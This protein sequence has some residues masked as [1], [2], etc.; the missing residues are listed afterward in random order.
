MRREGNGQRN[1]LTPGLFAP[2]ATADPLHAHVYPIN[3]HAEH[4]SYELLD[5]RGMLGRGENLDLVLLARNGQG[6][7]GLE[8]KVLLSAHS[9]LALQHVIGL[10]EALV[11][12]SSGYAFAAAVVEGL[13][14]YCIL[15]EIFFLN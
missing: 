15:G 11:Y 13:G 9:R 6:A 8:I 3:W 14:C 2:E 1:E 10:R 5:L 7:V 4:M 12:V